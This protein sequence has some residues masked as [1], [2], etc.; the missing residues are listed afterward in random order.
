MFSFRPKKSNNVLTGT[1]LSLLFVGTLAITG[2]DTANKQ[3]EETITVEVN[4]VEE[5]VNKVIASP[6]PKP[7]RGGDKQ[8]RVV[9]SINKFLKNKL[10][11]KGEVIYRFSKQRE[12]VVNPV[13]VTA[14]IIHELGEDCNSPLIQKT[15]NVA[16]INWTPDSPYS[17][18]GRYN[19]YRK[20]GGIDESILH[21]TKILSRYYIAQG[22]NSIDTIQQK[23]AP[24][25]DK[26]NGKYGMSNDVWKNNVTQIYKQIMKEVGGDD[27]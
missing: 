13:L 2:Y 23:Y 3:R 18:S 9:Q 5:D 17:R 15:D 16:G 22:Y 10:S 21:L 8:S 7:S 27:L 24:L 4:K 12:P 26:E 14:I 19:D 20:H 11:G 6:M 25:N 1:M